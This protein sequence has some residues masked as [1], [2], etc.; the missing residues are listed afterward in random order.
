MEREE[1]R[2]AEDLANGLISQADYNAEI[3]E[4]QREY[5][6]L[7]FEAAREEFERW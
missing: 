2:L 5:R 1:G 3:R 7:A 4:M 6:D